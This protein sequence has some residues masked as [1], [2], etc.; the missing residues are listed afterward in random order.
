MLVT[1][2]Q[3]ARRDL[4]TDADRRTHVAEFLV[5]ALLRGDIKARYEAYALGRQNTFLSAN[6]IRAFEN[7]NPIEGGDVYENPNI[8]TNNS[9]GAEA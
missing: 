5:A 1:W 9:A 3:S 7:L 6:E 8:A 2:E 4:F